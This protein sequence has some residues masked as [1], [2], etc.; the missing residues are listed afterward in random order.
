MTRWSFR[1]CGL[2]RVLLVAVLGMSG[3]PLPGVPARAAQS[4]ETSYISPDFGYSIAWPLPWYVSSEYVEPEV[5]T[6]ELSDD[7]SSVQ[8]SGALLGDESIQ[9]AAM[10]IVDS[11]RSDP[12]NANVALLDARTC[13]FP[14]DGAVLCYRSDT[15]LS[16]GSVVGVTGLVETRLLGNGV[17]LF[18]IA[19][20]REPH[21]AEY[22]AKWAVFEIA[23]PGAPVP[24]IASNGDWEVLSYGGATYRI[25][26]GVSAL[27]RD[28]AVQGVEYARR[29]VAAMAGRLSEPRL[30]VSVLSGASP[31]DPNQYGLARSKAIWVYTGSD[32]W[33]QISPIERL[34]GLVHEYFHLYQFDRLDLVDT[35]VPAWFIEGSADAFGYLAVSQ[36]G[37]TDQMDFVSLG[38]YRLGKVPVS[39]PLCDYVIDDETFSFEKYALA[40][41]AVQDLLARSGQSIDA[42]VRIF[43]EIGNGATFDT[44]FSNTFHADLNEFCAREPDWRATLA[45]VDVI[46]QDLTVHTGND[47]PSSVRSTVIPA[48]AAAGQQILITATTSAGSNCQ[49]TA[50][51]RG[52]ARRVT[53]ETFAN[54]S[55][56]AFWL[57]IVPDGTLPG[58]ALVSI[59]CGA[60]VV[61]QHFSVG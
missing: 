8:F 54:G 58:A 47:L 6:V 33:P 19:G 15:T 31:L 17:V 12:A 5:D 11:I 38:L 18:M 44:A 56:E 25:Q 10:G 55:G 52:G 22:L 30:T 24:A 20:V 59:D 39:G 29:S 60:N 13:S 23:G 48:K 14:T 3:L 9:Q 57:M 34:Q 4:A 26:P 32:S 61:Q 21:L 1:R 49:L 41:L 53:E 50:T 27:D 37:I 36:L 28:L 16:D 51:F 42:L 2:A 40:F 7:Q 35:L 45:Q 43:A 46:P